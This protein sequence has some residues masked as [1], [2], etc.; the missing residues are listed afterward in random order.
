[1]ETLMAAA[2][3]VEIF[4]A[5]LGLAAMFAALAIRGAFWL[6]RGTSHQMRFGRGAS[7][8]SVMNAGLRAGL[9]PVRVSTKGRVRG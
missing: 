1:M 6:M 5:S 3:V 4:L 8:A 2:A 7:S 9:V